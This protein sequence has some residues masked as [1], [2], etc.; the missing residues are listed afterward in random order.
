MPDSLVAEAHQ[1]QLFHERPTRRL[2]RLQELLH[3]QNERR[4]I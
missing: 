1:A 4:L 2:H 3:D